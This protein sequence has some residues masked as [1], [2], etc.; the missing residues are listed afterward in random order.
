MT[1][2]MTRN[3]YLVM[4]VIIEKLSEGVNEVTIVIKQE[5]L[6]RKAEDTALRVLLEELQASIADFAARPWCE[7]FFCNPGEDF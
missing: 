7:G 6:K 5:A 2:V 1:E 3:V 4:M